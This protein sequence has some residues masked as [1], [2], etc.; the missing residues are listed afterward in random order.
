[1]RPLAHLCDERIMNND[2]TNDNRT[3][4]QLWRLT[5]GQRWWFAGAAFAM[6]IANLC[7]FVP[8]VLGK[9][10]IDMVSQQDT[11]AMSPL[12]IAV[13][14]KAGLVELLIVAGSLSLF[15][16]LIAGVFLF[17]RGRFT[18][19]ASEAI[20]E[21]LRLN[22]YARLHATR[23]SFFDS[24][25]TGDL[26]QRCSS[27]VET[28]RAFLA[29]NLVD[30]SRSL[31]L[32]IC[33]TPVLFWIDTTLA[34]ASLCLTPLLILGS[35]LF[36]S[37][38]KV[39]FLKS[40][41]AEGRMTACLQENLTGIRVV[42]A[43]NRQAFE[44]DKFAECNE[45]FRECE[46]H[47]VKILAYFWSLSDFIS[48]SQ[49]GIVLIGGAV[50][51]QGGYISL[52]DLFAFIT[53]VSMVIWP[54]RH[55]GK[56]LVDSGMSMVALNRINHILVQPDESS[57]Q[58]PH[59]ARASGALRIQH[60]S[61]SYGLQS[62][63][64]GLAEKGVTKQDPESLAENMLQDINLDIA[65]GET[66]AIAGAPGSG[67]TTLIA[68]LLKLYE[69]Q[70]GSIELDG[71]E[72]NSLDKHWLR[73]QIAVVFQEPFL[74][75]RSITNNLRVGRA[76][77][78]DDDM[79]AACQDA[80]LHESIMRFSEHYNAVIGE[81]GVSLSGGQRQRLAIARALMKDTP[82]LILDDALSAVD[83]R[84]EKV[85][86]DALQS[87]AGT[88]TTLIVAHRL[89]TFR[90]ADRIAVMDAGK[91]V[92]LGTHAQLSNQVGHYQRLCAIQNELES[93][94]QA[95]LDT[96]NSPLITA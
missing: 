90:H 48:F 2:V 46:Y 55:L 75:S 31:L 28:V 3:T 34:L 23:A 91:V 14:G 18:A 50:R 78:S 30:I 21:Q 38:V 33:V 42:R 69:Y 76:D 51:V 10:V 64:K 80:A 47:M 27:D 63:E 62:V 15:M 65:A 4:R 19:R 49:I 35:Y 67:K 29:S 71:Y 79:Q 16:T 89:S 83:S 74:F 40:D 53:Y 17:L 5:R 26:V 58:V 11:A 85:I 68:L 7:L 32:L 73:N 66:L 59:I 1:M 41:E 82:I 24:E 25:K 6:I 77:A 57:G 43:F 8:P 36:F 72:I 39:L 13:Y 45:D 84:T 20:A 93:T 60:L 9:Y 56:V 96:T 92:Q 94:M 86:L 54:I 12:L 61:F 44:I 37:R 22:L 88:R 81:R 95:D 70:H 87:R 52:G